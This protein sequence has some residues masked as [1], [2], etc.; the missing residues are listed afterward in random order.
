MPLQLFNVMLY[1]GCLC[2]MGIISTPGPILP[3]QSVSISGNICFSGFF[4][5]EWMLYR[6]WQNHP[7]LLAKQFIKSGAMNNTLNN[8]HAP[9]Y[10]VCA[11]Y[12]F[13]LHIY[14][15]SVV[16]PYYPSQT[17]R[18]IGFPPR[19]ITPYVLAS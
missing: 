10:R 11:K 2:I 5:L 19:P 17:T 7:F 4:E 3:F 18:C 14:A 6:T 8:E 12:V 16:T 9:M 15:F 13:Q 1:L